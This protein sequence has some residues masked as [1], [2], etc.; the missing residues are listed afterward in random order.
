ME[1]KYILINCEIKIIVRILSANF[2]QVSKYF[3][4]PLY[5]TM[6]TAEFSDEH[7]GNVR[8]RRLC[9]IAYRRALSRSVD[10]VS[11]ALGVAAYF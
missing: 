11:S 10:A 9:E 5:I 4:E 8:M 6:K 7:R 3:R 2:V 1:L